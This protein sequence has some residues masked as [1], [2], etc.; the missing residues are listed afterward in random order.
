M[1]TDEIERRVVRQL[2][3]KVIAARSDPTHSSQ[4]WDNGPVASRVS[5]L[6]ATVEMSCAKVAGHAAA[7]P[8]SAD[9]C[10]NCL[11]SIL[12]AWPLSLLRWESRKIGVNLRQYLVGQGIGG[13]LL[14]RPECHPPR[15]VDLISG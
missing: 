11:R 5:M 14:Y 15:H 8:M 2:S 13:E 3:R 12:I 9:P 10:R 1:R 6:T 4:T 7:A